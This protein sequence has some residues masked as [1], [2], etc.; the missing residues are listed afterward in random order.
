MVVWE[1]GIDEVLPAHILRPHFSTRQDSPIPAL[2]DLVVLILAKCILLRFLVVVCCMAF[3]VTR[4]LIVVH[5][6]LEP[7]DF[8]FKPQNCGLRL[9]SSSR[10]VRGLLD[11]PSLWTFLDYG[12]SQCDGDDSLCLGKQ[13]DHGQGSGSPHNLDRK[14]Q[15]EFV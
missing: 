8:F 6:P 10:C 12:N 2:P 11:R 4:G 1:H 14:L 15:D 9:S 3:G 5:C 7:L 13:P